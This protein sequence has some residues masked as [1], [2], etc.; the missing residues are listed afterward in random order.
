M[1]EKYCLDRTNQSE[2]PEETFTVLHK[3][4]GKVCPF[5]LQ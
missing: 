2:E 1:R 4:Q 3:K 5:F